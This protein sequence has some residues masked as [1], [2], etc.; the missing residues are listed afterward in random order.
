MKS[1]RL[2]SA[3]CAL[4]LFP[5]I[6]FGGALKDDFASAKHPTRQ[7]LRGEWKFAENVA[8]CVSDPELYKKFKNHGP[9]LRWPTKFTDGTVAFELKAKGCS[10]IV[11]TL[12]EEGHVFRISLND[13]Q[14]TR[15]FGWVG[16]SSKTNKPKT[17]AKDG[18]PTAGAIDGKWMKGRMVFSGNECR[19]TL[20]DYTAKLNHPS[21]GR[22]KGEFTISFASGECAIRGVSVTPAEG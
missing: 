14:K 22:K 5:L 21:I 12:N 8:S 20:G 17:I 9:I 11:I 2:G 13:E 15:I 4:M 3:L 1:K 18:V 7:A 16:R 10:R 6:G 19:I